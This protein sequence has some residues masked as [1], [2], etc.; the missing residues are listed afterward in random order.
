MGALYFDNTTFLVHRQS[1]FI[2]VSVL[3]SGIIFNC[4]SFVGIFFFCGVRVALLFSP[5]DIP[6]TNTRQLIFLA[7]YRHFN[8]WLC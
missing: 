3:V 8:K 4:L 7:L 2:V 5:F 6:N 1:W